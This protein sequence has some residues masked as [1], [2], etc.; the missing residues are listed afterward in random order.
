MIFSVK[1]ESRKSKLNGQLI[2]AAAK[3]GI[4]FD[5]LKNDINLF[6]AA[7]SEVLKYILLLYGVYFIKTLAIWFKICYNLFDFI[8]F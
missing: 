4:R 5:V 2:I 6:A 1:M 7:I 3:H 8:L